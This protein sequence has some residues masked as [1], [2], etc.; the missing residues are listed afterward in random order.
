MACVVSLNFKVEV[1]HAAEVCI[2]LRD[3][4]EVAQKSSKSALSGN[5]LEARPTDVLRRQAQLMGARRSV[6]YSKY[7]VGKMEE[8][9][10]TTKDSIEYLLESILRSKNIGG[11]NLNSVRAPI[12][13]SASPEEG[14]RLIRAFICIKQPELRAAIIKLTTQIADDRALTNRIQN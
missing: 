3:G 10:P 2:D 12:E 4:E 6:L 7:L 13:I 11:G 9:E 1:A 5:G 8:K 14:V